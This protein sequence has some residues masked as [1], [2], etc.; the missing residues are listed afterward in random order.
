MIHVAQRKKIYEKK[1]TRG[2]RK[3]RKKKTSYV[4][5]FARVSRSYMA[6]MRPATSRRAAEKKKELSPKFEDETV[7]ERNPTSKRKK[8]DSVSK[9]KSSTFFFFYTKQTRA[10]RER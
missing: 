9:M 7:S 1:K 8:K 10:S 6:Y 3:A 5:V 2:K 4:Q